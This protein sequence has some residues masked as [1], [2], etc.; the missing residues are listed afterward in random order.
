MQQDD[1]VDDGQED[2]RD[3]TL[4]MCELSPYE[5]RGGGADVG[6]SPFQ[7][8]QQ[9]EESSA[10]INR[11]GWS[12]QQKNIKEFK[13][14]KFSLKERNN[15]NSVSVRHTQP[16]QCTRSGKSSEM[17]SPRRETTKFGQMIA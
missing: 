8:E 5:E 16:Q 4:T 7:H 11:I 6:V 10:I 13:N 17:V 15:S 3:A 2:L 1:E 9:Q 12:V 14:S